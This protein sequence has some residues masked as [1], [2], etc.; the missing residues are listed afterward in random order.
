MKS[1]G[2]SA[3]QKTSRSKAVM[4]ASSSASID[5]VVVTRADSAASKPR[6]E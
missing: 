1:C 4:P 3:T 5:A 6:C 2:S